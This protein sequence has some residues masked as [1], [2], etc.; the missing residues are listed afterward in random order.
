M[1]CGWFPV[2]RQQFVDQVGHLSMDADE[3][4]DKAGLWVEAVE[5][6]GFD[7]IHGAGVGFASGI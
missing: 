6:D 4:A 5:P 7:D 1:C 2:P 3:D